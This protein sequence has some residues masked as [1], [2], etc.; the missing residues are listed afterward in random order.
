MAFRLI[1]KALD[2]RLRS[3]IVLN[4]FNGRPLKLLNFSTGAMATKRAPRAAAKIAVPPASM[5]TALA[6]ASSS[7]DTSP[8]TTLVQALEHIPPTL[9][10]IETSSND[11]QTPPPAEV[12]QVIRHHVDEHATAPSKR[13][14]A[15]AK[16]T[17]YAETSEPEEAE[18]RMEEKPASD[19]KKAVKKAVKGEEAETAHA[20]MSEPEEAEKEVEEKPKK[21]RKKAVKKVDSADEDGQAEMTPKKKRAT[22]KKTV[23]EDGDE[24]AEKP[25]KKVTPK[26]SR[27]AKDEPEHDSEGN[28]IIKKKRKPKEYPK[29]EYEIPPVERKETTFRGQYRCL[30]DNIVLICGTGRLGYAC[31][32]TVLRSTK[33]DSIFCSR[34]CRIASIEEEGM[35]LPKGLALMNARD[36][37]TMIEVCEFLSH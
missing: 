27:L 32:N 17:T 28:E 4:T 30:I 18:E 26:K 2:R 29:I 6:E 34:T 33:P 22:P 19:R 15:S 24:D 3:S 37:L 21:G 31:L 36:L 9:P 13:K 16:T 23:A 20:H 11:S 1:F 35:E 12:D 7:P 5:S 10:K 25:K 8:G 14:R